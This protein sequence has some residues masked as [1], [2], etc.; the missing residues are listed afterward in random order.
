[1]DKG[2]ATLGEEITAQENIGE[3]KHCGFKDCEFCLKT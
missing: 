3:E 2:L 1:M